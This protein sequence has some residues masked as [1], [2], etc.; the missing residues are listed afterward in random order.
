MRHGRALFAHPSV[1]TD[2][3][4]VHDHGLD[5]TGPSSV[6]LKKQ[7]NSSDDSTSRKAWVD[8]DD[9]PEWTDE[10]VARAEISEGG[11]IIRGGRPPPN[12]GVGGTPE[13]G[14]A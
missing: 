7:K 10:M 4:P 14:K 2:S 3:F 12:S 8:P 5:P 1:F 6:M 11:K 9:A 13:P